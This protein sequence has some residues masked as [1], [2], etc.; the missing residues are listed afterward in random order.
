MN[1]KARIGLAAD[2][3]DVLGF[4]RYQYE[5]I[6]LL[7]K[8]LIQKHGVTK[9]KK[10]QVDPAYESLRR[11]KDCYKGRR[12]FIVATGPSLTIEDVEK[13]EGEITFGVNSIA[14]I[15][16]KTEW[17]PTYLGIQDP[18]VYEKLE[19]TI[20]NN[21]KTNVLAGDWL[22]DYYTVPD[23]YIL[24]PCMLNHKLYMNRYKEYNTKYSDDAYAVVYDGYS[25]TYSMI[26][27]A[28]YM[29]INEIY[30]LGCDC[31]YPKG[32][33]NH[34]IESGFVDKRAY[35]NGVRMNAGYRVAKKYADDNGISIINCTRGGMLEVFP[36][37]DLDEVVKE[38]K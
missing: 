29:G 26:Q 30:L 16:D 8:Y 37:K 17:R 20:C 9:R 38:K 35:L 10:G 23:E 7:P 4:L 27:I 19:D 22:L 15:I 25:I 31:N 3:N 5:R 14:K 32:E 33:K 21:F 34:F 2:R 13:L 6:V 36:R 12:A 28:T 1:I 11:M 18:F 24:F